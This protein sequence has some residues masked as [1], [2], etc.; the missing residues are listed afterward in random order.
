MVDLR[1]GL[2][3]VVKSAQRV[4]AHFILAGTEP[5]DRRVSVGHR[6]IPIPLRQRPDAFSDLRACA[7]TGQVIDGRMDPAPDTGDAG[8]VG[9]IV[10]RGPL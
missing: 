3:V 1:R 8:L 5:S 7:A 9:G 6:A 2:E 10:K 4:V